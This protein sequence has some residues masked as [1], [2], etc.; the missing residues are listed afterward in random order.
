[1]AGLFDRLLFKRA[2]AGALR[3][4]IENLESAFMRQRLRT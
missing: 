1:L 2:V 4:T 3:K